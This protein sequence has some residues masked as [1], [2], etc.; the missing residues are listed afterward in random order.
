MKGAVAVA[1][2]QSETWK[3]KWNSFGR[4]YV[5]EIGCG[6]RMISVLMSWQLTADACKTSLLN[7]IW[8]SIGPSTHIR[9]LGTAKAK[10]VLVW[11]SLARLSITCRCTA[12]LYM[13]KCMYCIR[14]CT[15][16][17]LPTLLQW[18]SVHQGQQVKEL[19]GSW[20]FLGPSMNLA[21][22]WS[23]TAGNEETKDDED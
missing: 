4:S 14:D 2:I 6:Q 7:K 3:P 5:T 18:E 19:M 10:L 11:Q 20:T 1:T 13:R 12:I 22:D 16:T 15:R 23:P 17:C 8:Q 21:D 9:L